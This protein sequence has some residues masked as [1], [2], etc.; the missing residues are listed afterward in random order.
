MARSW[1]AGAGMQMGGLA[2]GGREYVERVGAWSV[3][4]AGAAGGGLEPR[5]G[6]EGEW[7]RAG[8]GAARRFGERGGVRKGGL[9]VGG[10]CGRRR[11][12]W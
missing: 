7:A 10:V 8:M 12:E 3:C 1:G 4:G 11:V 6:K 9:N 5:D 2:G